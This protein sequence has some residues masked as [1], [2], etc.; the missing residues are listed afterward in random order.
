MAYRAELAHVHAPKDVL[1][2]IAVVSV[3]V[4]TT[5]LTVLVPVEI[6]TTAVGGCLVALTFG[7]GFFVLS[8]IW[9]PFLVLLLGTS[10]LW[11]HAWYLRPI[12]LVPG[13]VIAIV[14][15][16][17]VMLTPDPEKDA[18]YAKLSIAQE[19]PLSWYLIKPPKEYYERTELVSE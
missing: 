8:L 2:R 16:L 15:N 5:A 3:K 13:I 11:L 14:A 7:V 19:W 10:W 4:A 12:L 1:T 18:K 6:V 17:Y 9:L